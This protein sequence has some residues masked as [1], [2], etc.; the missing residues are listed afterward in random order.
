LAEKG[1]LELE[2]EEAEVKQERR[3]RAKTEQA[4][5]EAREPWWKRGKPWEP[6]QRNRSR[7]LLPWERVVQSGA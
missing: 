6:R 2:D 1:F 4:R 5:A 3:A 7:F